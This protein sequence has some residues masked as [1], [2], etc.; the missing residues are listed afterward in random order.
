MPRLRR[1]HTFAAAG[2]LAAL[3]AAPAAAAPAKKATPPNPEKKAPA[4]KKAAGPAPGELTT[5]SGSALGVK[6]EV[7]HFTLDNGMRVYVVEDHSTPVFSIHL[8]FNV[9]SRDEPEG[10]T[11]FAHFF[12]HMMFKGSENIPEGGH[13]KYVF[14][15]G[16]EMNAFTMADTTQYFNILP[17]HYLDLAL[18]LE[19]DRM[20]SLAITD[21]NFENQRNAVKEERA[22]RVENVPYA[23]GLLDFFA[24]VWKGTGYGHMALGSKEDLDAATTA[25]VKAF[26]DKYYVP[27]NMVVAIVGDVEAT[28]VRDKVKSYFGDIPRG[29]DREAFKPIDHK[30]EKL[31]R[32]VEDKLAQ[33]PLYMIGW[34]TVPEAHADRHAVEILMNIMLRGDSSRI[35]KILIDEKK[36]AVASVP[37]PSML[38]GGKD[39]G[40]SLGAFIP[41]QGASLDSIKAVIQEEIATVKRRGISGKELQKAV[42]Q[43]TV[44]TVTS[45][46][47]NNG[48]AFLIAQGALHWNDPTYVLTDLEKYRKVTARDIKRVAN[49]YLTDKWLVLEVAPKK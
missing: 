31:E 27:N 5:I 47:T 21:E 42:N 26:F 6:M 24:E 3:I 37:L 44:D 43:L 34:K 30:Q 13:F 9:G 11:G 1:L 33:Q 45:L 41:V 2:A 46:A 18:W 8:A 4:A 48:R 36:L 38:A 7:Q 25:D 14:N 23:S 19:S 15:A 32:K 29:A 17:S 22:M 49:E 28:T 35:T 20:K 12:E 40:T 16:G 10:R 39:A